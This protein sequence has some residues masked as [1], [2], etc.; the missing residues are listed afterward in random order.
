MLPSYKEGENLKN[1]LPR[2]HKA[3]SK[4]D[5]DYEILIVDTMTPMDDTEEVCRSLNASYIP[6]ENGNFYGDAIRTGISKA[7]GEYLVIM[8]ADGSHD[9]EEILKFHSVMKENPGVD[10]VIGSRYCKGGHTD[11]NFILRFM[12]WI[13]NVSYRLM[14]GLKIKDV[15][16][17]FRMYKLDQ[18]RKLSLECSNF[19]IVEELLI[20]LSVCVDDF[21]PREVPISFNKRAEGESKRDLFK[22]ILSYISTMNRLMKIKRAAKKAKAVR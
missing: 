19:D 4:L 11:N 3:L 22:F 12:S 18:L 10:L 9:P 16:D 1:I 17:S 7:S 6:R 21:E 20:K 13:L 2:I 15:S 14:F 8:D 5:D